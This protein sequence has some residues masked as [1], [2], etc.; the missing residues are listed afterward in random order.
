MKMA[1]FTKSASPFVNYSANKCRKLAMVVEIAGVRIRI[2]ESLYFGESAIWP[3]SYL[4]TSSDKTICN[5]VLL[6]F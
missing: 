4:V 1:A 5:R 6:C 3:P 2:F